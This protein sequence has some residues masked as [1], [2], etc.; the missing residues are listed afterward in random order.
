MLA[1]CTPW[2]VADAERYR[3]R[4]YWRSQPL[5]SI[6]RSPARGDGAVAVVDGGRDHT[7]G[8]LS[9]RADRLASGLLARGLRPA[10]RVVVQLPNTVDFVVTCIALFRAGV[11]PVLAMPGLRR[12]ELGHLCTHTDAV[13]LIMP[14]I[15]QGF[16]H[17]ELARDLVKLAPGLREV[18]IAGDPG[19]FAALRDAGTDPTE[20]PP[21]DP[22]EVAF[23]L[24]SGGTTNLP[25]LIPRT[26]DD[27]AYQMRATAA[28]IGFDHDS[29]YVAALPVAHNAA[30]GCPGVL[31]ALLAGGTALLAGTPSPDDVFPLLERAGTAG[32]VATTLMPSLLP[33]WTEAAR[34]QGASFPRLVV[35]VGG[36][37]IDGAVCREHE[38][39][40]GCRVTRW[41]G[42]AE[43]PLCFTRPHDPV[44]HRLGN[45]GF[46]LSVDDDY[47]VVAPDGS[48]CATGETGELLVRG[49]TT[50]RGYYRD[51][52]HNRAAFT[53]DGFLRTGDMAGLDV[54]GSLQIR[55]RMT[56]VVNRGGEK[57]PVALVESKLLAHPGV[58]ACAVTTMP[59]PV[60][61][62][63]VA[64]FVVAGDPAP[65]LAELG[66]FL[67]DGDL[68]PHCI[69]EE[70][71]FV[72]R[73]P[74]TNVGKVDKKA[75]QS[76]F[77]GR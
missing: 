43:G 48:L 72:E 57:V 16:D 49:P 74:M 77:T 65:T 20:L 73:L 27:Y 24:L 51:A 15:W 39:A 8:E 3:Q 58:R 70:L 9:G 71:V 41:F 59:D 10:D 69:P 34:D 56:D 36:A 68:A 61:I 5:G 25:K 44:E 17:R 4:N 12:T 50:L 55:G 28:A 60:L 32:T 66:G 46:P 30:L 22:A 67:R 2:P 23:F 19:E 54:D 13:A 45:E 7:F 40:L 37:N 63:K 47:R 52:E 1:G 29:A 11:L 64:A 53:A 75:L 26:H 62:E 14:D 21:A 6:L 42:M 31:G 38:E 33:I 76:R 35:E 18:L